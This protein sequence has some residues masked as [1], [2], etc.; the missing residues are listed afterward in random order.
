MSFLAKVEAAHQLPSLGKYPM[1]VAY[2]LDSLNTTPDPNEMTPYDLEEFIEE[3]ASELNIELDLH[4][5]SDLDIDV[6]EE[7]DD[8][9][10]GEEKFEASPV[11]KQIH[12]DYL[13][14]Y[15][16]QQT[17]PADARDAYAY[18]YL[19]VDVESSKILA[20]GCSKEDLKEDVKDYRSSGQKTKIV[21]RAKIKPDAFT[22][23]FNA[24]Y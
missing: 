4:D 7:D 10:S 19:V 18:L 3:A 17:L 13:K 5:D 21:S 22:A 11:A 12:A 1:I 6:E 2:M 23:F 14:A 9:E 16:F 15:N 8:D 20:G 24:N